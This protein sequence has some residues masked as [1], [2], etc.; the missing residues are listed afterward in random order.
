[1]SVSAAASV[2]SA[3]APSSGRAARA[4]SAAGVATRPIEDFDAYRQRLQQFVYRSAF[5]MKPVFDKARGNLERHFARRTCGELA[6]VHDKPHVKQVRRV[7]G[8]IYTGVKSEG[9]YHFGGGACG[10][11]D[12]VYFGRRF[13]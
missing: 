6:G 1:M 12:N 11:I 2:A 3:L 13:V 8:N 7:F 4:A 5:V 10:G 9:G